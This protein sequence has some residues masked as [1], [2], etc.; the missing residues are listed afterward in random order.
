VIKAAEGSLDFVI[1]GKLA[2]LCLRKPFEY[3]RQMRRVERL[4]LY[5]TARQVKNGA[6][7]V[8]LGVRR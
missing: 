2:S 5:L 7:D 3:R 8:I 1:R 4:D 6:G